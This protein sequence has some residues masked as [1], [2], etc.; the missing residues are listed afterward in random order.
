MGMILPL[1]AAAMSPAAPGDIERL[2]AGLGLQSDDRSIE[3]IGRF[4]CRAVPALVRQLEVVWVVRVLNDE[5]Q[6]YPREA[7]VVWTI[8]ALRHITDTDFHAP[9]PSWFDRGSTSVRMLT[10]G[11]PPGRTKFF[12]VWESRGSYYF[13]PPAQQRAII[14]QWRRY[15]ASG[16]CRRAR[17]NPDFAF[18]LHGMRY[19]HLRV[20]SR[21]ATDVASP[22]T[23]VAGPAWTYYGT[24]RIGG[25]DRESQ[26]V[27]ED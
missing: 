27:P 25:S 24:V 19:S 6:L 4:G 26:P 12:G 5:A 9:R 20:L 17:P 2:V 22:A 8:A 18:W 7:R 21:Y 16:A 10:M 23:Q 1:I 3:T 14:A 15:S 13:A 11:A